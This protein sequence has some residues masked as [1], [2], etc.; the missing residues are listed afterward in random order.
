MR[1]LRFFAATCALGIC[2]LAAAQ[3]TTSQVAKVWFG[4][5]I[6]L[7]IPRD[8][9][10]DNAELQTHLA[11]AGSDVLILQMPS[12]T[13][14]TRHTLLDGKRTT[15][16]RAS[17]KVRVRFGRA[18]SQ[19]QTRAEGGKPRE[20]ILRKLRPALEKVESRTRQA[21]GVLDAKADGRIALNRHVACIEVEVSVSHA[22]GQATALTWNCPAGDMTLNLSLR[23][24][25]DAAAIVVPMIQ[26]LRSTLR[27]H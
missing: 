16:P 13:E 1:S 11:K 25:Q 14:N 20:E 26:H 19:A 17:L 22:A 6:Y 15:K 5:R 8:W 23:F 24:P 4:E 10:Y 27:V 2:G 12:P 18:P 21:R 7:E 9:T 3:D